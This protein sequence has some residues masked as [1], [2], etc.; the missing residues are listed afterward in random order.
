ME[1]VTRIISENLKKVRKERY[2]TLQGLADLTGVSKS[3]L[4]EIERGATNPTITVLWKIAR[5]LRMPFSRLITQG[6]EQVMQVKREQMEPVVE[7]AGYDVFS[8]FQFDED[9]QF[10]VFM[11]E[12]HPGARYTAEAHTGN[13]EEHVLVGQGELKLTLGEEEYLLLEGEA[14]KF[15]GERAHAYENPGNR[16]ARIF[17]ILHYSHLI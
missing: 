15:T 16:V 9:T 3:M 8:I 17:F 5:G 2:L 11:E 12:I 7:G 10:E 1:Q 14:M 4:G 6:R 13:V